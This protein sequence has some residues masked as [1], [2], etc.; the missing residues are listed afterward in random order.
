MSDSWLGHQGAKTEN[1]KSARTPELMAGSSPNFILGI[2]NKD[3]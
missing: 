2:S 3:T 1:T